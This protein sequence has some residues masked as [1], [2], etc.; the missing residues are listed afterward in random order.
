MVFELN[1]YSDC[2]KNMRIK[3]IFYETV[4]KGRFN[5]YISIHI[6]WSIFFKVHD[7]FEEVS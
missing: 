3:C 4:L 1:K 7:V 2:N 5:L 6:L